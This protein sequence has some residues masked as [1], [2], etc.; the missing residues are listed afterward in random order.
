MNASNY[1]R[2]EN[3]EVFLASSVAKRPK[4]I[5][6]IPVILTLLVVFLAVFAAI[7]WFFLQQ[8]L[9]SNEDRL[10]DRSV[11]AAQVVANNAFWMDQLAQQT[12]RRV[13][14]AIGPN[15][16]DQDRLDLVVE[17]LPSKAD[18]YIADQNGRAVFSTVK[19]S[20][21]VSIADRGYFR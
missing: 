15:V 14:A 12:L 16:L 11:A 9:R 18:L 4:G 2:P 19:G 5:S 17:G 10:Q 3:E 6:A 1:S 21:S 13:D 20:E 7:F 8:G